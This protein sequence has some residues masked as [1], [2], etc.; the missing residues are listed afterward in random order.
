MVENTKS[1]IFIKG[2]NVS[3][4]ITNVFKDLHVLKQPNST[5]YKKKNIVRPFEDVSSLEFF[6]KK[7]DASLIAFGSHNKKR[8]HNLVIGRTF[9]HQILDMA[10]FGI[11]NFTPLNKNNTI[12]AETKPM[13]SFAGDQWD[14]KLELKD[15]TEIEWR[16]IRSLLVDFFRGQQ[17][18][19]VRR[20]GLELFIQFTLANGVISMRSYKVEMR[21]SGLEEPRVELSSVG[22]DMDLTFRR[23]QLANQ[24]TFGKACKCPPEL[25][26]KKVKNVT[27]DPLTKEV[28]GQ[29]HLGKQKQDLGNINLGHKKV[30]KRQMPENTEIDSEDER[31]FDQEI[32]TNEIEFESDEEVMEQ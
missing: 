17:V 8:P 15:G 27:I 3:D 24:T 18:N 2:G 32:E 29:V 19:S 20:K 10:E 30:F 1:T 31:E 28:R 25:R 16:R 14:T 5:M 4:V 7:S 9:D 21:K 6:S 12:P 13:L 26:Q 23:A 22:P 11:S